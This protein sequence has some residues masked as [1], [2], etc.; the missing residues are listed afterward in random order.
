M[1]HNLILSYFDAHQGTDYNSGR[2]RGERD[3]DALGTVAYGV[4]S[5]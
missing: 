3:E 1:N 2:E 5:V 4:Y